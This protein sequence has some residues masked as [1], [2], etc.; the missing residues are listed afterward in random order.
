MNELCDP[1]LYYLVCQIYAISQASVTLVKPVHEGQRG[2]TTQSRHDDPQTC[3]LDPAGLADGIFVPAFNRRPANG[4]IQTRCWFLLPITCLESPL[5]L[6]VEH[7]R[8]ATGVR[9][10]VFW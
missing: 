6:A 7:A 3:R 8:G 10:M 5:N 4:T 1:E 9:R 2:A